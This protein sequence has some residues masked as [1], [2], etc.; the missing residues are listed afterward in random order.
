MTRSRTWLVA[1]ATLAGLATGWA[2]SQGRQHHHRADLFSNRPFR[3]YAALGYLAGRPTV[4]H[5]RL[6]RDYL[7]WE[8]EPI[9]VRRARQI[10][11]RFEARLG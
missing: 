11:R 9:L 5:R 10:L 4:E 2:V 7:S 3:R 1:A 8:R 6:L